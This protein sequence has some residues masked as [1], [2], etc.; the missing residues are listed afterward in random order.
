MSLNRKTKAILYTV[1][2]IGVFGWGVFHP[3]LELNSW[4]KLLITAAIIFADASWK[5]QGDKRYGVIYL[6]FIGLIIGYTY[7]YFF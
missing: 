3:S 7:H 5:D 6:Y 2:G 1:W 4:L